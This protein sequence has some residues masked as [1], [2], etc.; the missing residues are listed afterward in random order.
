MSAAVHLQPS[1][2]LRIVYA[3]GNENAPG[4]P[5]GE[6]VLILHGDG[7]ARLDNRHAG[8][9][10]AFTGRIDAATLT[11]IVDGLNLAGF[12]VVPPHRISPGATRSLTVRSGDAEHHILPMGWH[13]A[14]KIAG[15]REVFHL[16]D[17]IIV[18]IAGGAIP[19]IRNAEPGLVREAA[20]VG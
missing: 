13:A 11:R 9:A 3:S 18:E 14:P 20:A 1:D 16:L 6:C 17:S 7:G 19:L 12:P 15:Y 10:R 2:D 5:F 8:K 4:D